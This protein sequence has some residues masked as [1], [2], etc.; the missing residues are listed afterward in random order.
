MF[1]KRNPYLK[2][3]ETA[4]PALAMVLYAAVISTGG[5]CVKLETFS[6]LQLMIIFQKQFDANLKFEELIKFHSCDQN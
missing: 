6:A 1:L 4:N 3:S 2:G 5:K